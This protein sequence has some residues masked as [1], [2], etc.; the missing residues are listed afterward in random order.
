MQNRLVYEVTLKIK[1][2]QYEENGEMYMIL[3]MGSVWV[4]R[5]CQSTSST[6]RL[7]AMLLMNWL[8]TIHCGNH[9]MMQKKDN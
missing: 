6:I 2:I 9:G 5:T 7:E 4:Y 3:S 8:L 1:L